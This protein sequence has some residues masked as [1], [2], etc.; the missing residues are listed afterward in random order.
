MLEQETLFSL[1]D[2]RDEWSIDVAHQHQ[3]NPVGL[4]RNGL[5]VVERDFPRDPQVVGTHEQDA[6]SSEH[7]DRVIARQIEVGN[8]GILEVSPVFCAGRWEV[9]GI[10]SRWMC[11]RD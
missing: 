4:E 2:N 6:I 10:A 9:S 8:V 1:P 11:D 3:T 5:Q 7:D